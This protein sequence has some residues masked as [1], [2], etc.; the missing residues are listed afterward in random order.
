MIGGEKMFLGNP[1]WRFC[2]NLVET[3]AMM[4]QC[5]AILRKYRSSGSCFGIKTFSSYDYNEG[6][7]THG[8]FRWQS[9]FVGF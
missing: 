6:T 8:N 2:S 7:L 9:W 5:K 1:G 3:Q 4:A